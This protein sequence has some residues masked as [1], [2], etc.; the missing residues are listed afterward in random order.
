M[1]FQAWIFK[2]L[3]LIIFYDFFQKI[4]LHA[5]TSVCMYVGGKCTNNDE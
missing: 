5:L 3:L 1:Y 2:K 4:K